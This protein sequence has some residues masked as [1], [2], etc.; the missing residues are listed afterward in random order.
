MPSP[1]LAD[2]VLLLHLAYVGFVVLGFLAVPL[3][4]A[5][6]W[7]WV[8]GRALRRLH[9]AAIALV[10]LEAL[11]GVMCPLT[12]WEAQLRGGGTPQSFVG[13]L[14]HAVLFYDLPVWVFT[15]AYVGLA[16]LALVLYRL[17]PPLPRTSSGSSAR[18]RGDGAPPPSG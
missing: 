11:A 1:L 10:A 17:V 4:A 9:L 3:G 16:A 14:V 18:P 12:E 15:L 13:R 6:G 2:A 5:L 8:R 7:R